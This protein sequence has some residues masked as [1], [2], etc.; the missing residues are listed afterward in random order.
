VLTAP[1]V[2]ALDRVTIGFDAG[3][4]LVGDTQISGLADR[5][6]TLFRA[7][8]TRWS[9]CSASATGSGTVPANCPAGSSSGSPARA[10]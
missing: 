5:E 6:L 2:Q 3:A 9:A 7:G 1:A 8:S 4:S 10:L